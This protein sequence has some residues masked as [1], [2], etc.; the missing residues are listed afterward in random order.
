MRFIH[1]LFIHPIGLYQARYCSRYSSGQQPVSS[2]A[3]SGERS[4]NLKTNSPIHYL[5]I[6]INVPDLLETSR[7]DGFSGFGSSYAE[8]LYD[9]RMEIDFF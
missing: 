6:M 5:T 2:W 9:F 8:G 1:S 3:H 4:K 7:P